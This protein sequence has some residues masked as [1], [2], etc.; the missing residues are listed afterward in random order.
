[1]ICIIVNGV[2]GRLA[3][4]STLYIF[5]AWVSCLGLGS[6]FILGMEW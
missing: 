4:G 2:D 5:C 3:D 6:L 1:M